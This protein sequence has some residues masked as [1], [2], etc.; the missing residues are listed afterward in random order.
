[1]QGMHNN[2]P[3]EAKIRYISALLD[4]GFDTIDVGSLVS[5]RLVP[6]MRDTKEV[7][8]H[9]AQNG[10][11]TRLLVIVANVR[12][13]QEACAEEKI[14]D[15]GYPLSLS[16][17]FQQNNTGKSIAASFA[18]VKRIQK[19]AQRAHKRLV[20]YLSMGFGNPYGEPYSLAMVANFLVR[21]QDM[22]IQVVSLSDT[23][24]VA[25]PEQIQQLSKA[26]LLQCPEMEIGLHLHAQPAHASRI[27]S[28]ALA[29]HCQRIDSVIGGYGGCPMAQNELVA[30]LPTELIVQELAKKQRLP[31]TF[32]PAAF[33]SARTLC[34]ATFDN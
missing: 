9:V 28:A 17:T 32:N 12:G 22:G 31:H 5:H 20:L 6:Q 33:S 26:S 15:I 18:V 14:Q 23:I 11:D 3:T 21:L 8:A 2:I 25:T 1:M 13:A 27:V 10:T 34:K 4:V 16:E 30:N 7:L 24:G 19:A 29:S